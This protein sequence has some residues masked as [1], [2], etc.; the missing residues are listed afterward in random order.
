L[1]AVAEEQV[2]ANGDAKA[3]LYRRTFL[4]GVGSGVAQAFIRNVMTVKVLT[5]AKYKV[6]IHNL[7][8]LSV[9]A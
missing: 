7:I 5:D 4:H 9:I 1:L 6:F 3:G 8:V 2:L